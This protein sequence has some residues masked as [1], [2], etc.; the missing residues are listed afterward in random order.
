MRTYLYCRAGSLIFGH[1]LS[2][3]LHHGKETDMCV[4]VHYFPSTV[5]FQAYRSVLVVVS[6][7][8]NTRKPLGFNSNNVV[9][10]FFSQ[11]GKI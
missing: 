5:Q 10:F 6:S 1:K 7:G 3:S 4:S 9:N 11:E 2:A 8:R